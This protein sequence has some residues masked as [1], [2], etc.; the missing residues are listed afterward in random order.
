MQNIYKDHPRF[1]KVI[2][3]PFPNILACYLKKRLWIIAASK[4][5]V[6]EPIAV[7]QNQYKKPSAK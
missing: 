1:H 5:D 6:L 3:C 4:V 7:G 2:V